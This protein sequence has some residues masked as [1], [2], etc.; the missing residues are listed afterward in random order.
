MKILIFG[1]SGASVPLVPNSLQRPLNLTILTFSTELRDKFYVTL[2]LDFSDTF[3][4]A[5]P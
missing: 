4:N 5:D 1:A 2:T 3:K